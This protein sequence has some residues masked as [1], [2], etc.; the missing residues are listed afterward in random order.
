MKAQNPLLQGWAL[1]MVHLL[2]KGGVEALAPSSSRGSGIRRA[3]APIKSSATASAKEPQ[4]PIPGLRHR[5]AEAVNLAEQVEQ[6][7]EWVPANAGMYTL[8]E[9]LRAAAALQDTHT[10][11][12]ASDTLRQRHHLMAQSAQASA[13]SNNRRVMERRSTRRG[14]MLKSGTM[15]SGRTSSASLNSSL[16]SLHLSSGGGGGAGGAGGGAGAR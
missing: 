5:S 11:V 6:L 9:L 13:F 2:E 8:E 3:S 10:R 16:H 12:W 7:G 4:H 1:L 14:T 15:R